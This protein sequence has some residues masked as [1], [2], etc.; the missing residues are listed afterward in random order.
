MV[1][2]SEYKVLVAN[3]DRCHHSSILV[4]Q[5]VAVQHRLA[6]VVALV[7][8]PNA[9]PAV[10]R[11]HHDVPPNV[12]IVLQQILQHR[13][14]LRRK[15]RS[16]LL[17]LEPIDVD[18]ERVDVVVGVD[19]D[20]LHR[21][22]GV[23]PE[24][25]LVGVEGP[26]VDVVLRERGLVPVGAHRKHNVLRFDNVVRLDLVLLLKSRREGHLLDGRIGQLGRD[27]PVDRDGGQDL[28]VRVAPH[29]EELHPLYALL[30]DDVPPGL[31][32]LQQDLL[33]LA[34]GHDQDVLLP[35]SGVR[36]AVGRNDVEG[37]GRLVP[38]LVLLSL[39]VHDEGVFVLHDAHEGAEM[40]HLSHPHLKVGGHPPI[41]QE[42]MDLGQRRLAHEE[43]VDLQIVPPRAVEV[44][45]HF[46]C[47]VE[48]D[49][50]LRPR[51]PVRCQLVQ[52][53]TGD[54]QQPEHAAP[55][56]DGRAA[57]QVGMVPV[58]AA[59]M[60]LGDVEAVAV[61]L[62]GVDGNVGGAG[63]GRADGIEH[64]DLDVEAVEVEVGGIEIVRQIGLVDD[65]LGWVVD[66]LLVE[67]VLDL[68]PGLLQHPPIIGGRHL[69]RTEASVGLLVDVDLVGRQIV[70][71]LDPK[72]LARLDPERRSHE[73]VTMVGIGRVRPAAVHV[74]ARFVSTR[75]DGLHRHGADRRRQLVVDVA[76]GTGVR[77]RDEVGRSGG[78][79]DDDDRT[80]RKGC[81]CNENEND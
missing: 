61:A 9:R 73:S 67:L 1:L 52:E 75:F 32:E 8:D 23:G 37:Y 16:H 44:V 66:G 80:G 62:A 58:H 29:I 17:D 7:V 46:E 14:A 48:N 25:D 27:R 64:V 11:Y 50:L 41:D 18:V 13:I 81:R 63:V 78:G 77:A 40:Q 45:D 6:G 26:A 20:V 31:V 30:A 55:H 76:P 79:I 4:R 65:H 38:M 36:D 42:G 21:L 49:K 15:L 10:R 5:E 12:R 51:H 28:I 22:A 24:P 47:R 60:V 19:Q 54:V 33:P 72:G 68:L 59:G 34:T 2:P 56:L 3:E 74:V 39:L 35:G 69:V 43:L 57:V 53:R 71:E 70:P